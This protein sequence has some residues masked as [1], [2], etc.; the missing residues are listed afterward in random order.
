[1][2]CNKSGCN[3]SHCPD[4]HFSYSSSVLACSPNVFSMFPMTSANKPLVD[5]DLI[6]LGSPEEGFVICNRST[7]CATEKICYNS[8]T[9]EYNYQVCKAYIIRI[10]VV[11]KSRGELVQ[12]RDRIILEF[13][14]SRKQWIGCRE[15]SAPVGCRRRSQELTS[16]NTIR[17]VKHEEFIIY[18]LDI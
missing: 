10:N 12:H 4:Q 5:G 16:Q 1:M 13:G 7:K 3:V 15:R 2:A 14:I 9:H 17:V 18:K 11:G 6:V 8:T